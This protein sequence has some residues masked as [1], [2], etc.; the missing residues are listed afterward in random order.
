MSAL[1]ST[2][3]VKMLDIFTDWQHVIPHAGH[4]TTKC[5]QNSSAQRACRI[6]SENITNVTKLRIHVVTDRHQCSPYQSHNSARY[7]SI[8]GAAEVR[9]PLALWGTTPKDNNDK[10]SPS[11]ALY[12]HRKMPL[13][14]QNLC[15]HCH[16]A[17]SSIDLI[18]PN[19]VQ[20]VDRRTLVQTAGNSRGHGMGK[21][22][23]T[24]ITRAFW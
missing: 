8:L 17:L 16:D 7:F 14:S 10:F 3:S 18:Q 1:V 19:G 4:H 21:I 12:G 6:P 5:F 22:V 24:I 13:S 11:M 20:R 15:K 23:A 2:I 9:C